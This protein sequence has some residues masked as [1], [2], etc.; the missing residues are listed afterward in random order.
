MAFKLHISELSTICD[1]MRKSKVWI[2]NV[3]RDA[4]RLYG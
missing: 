4:V 1:T 2:M 3:S